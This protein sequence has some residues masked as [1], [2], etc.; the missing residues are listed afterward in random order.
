M[1]TRGESIEAGCGASLTKIAAF[2]AEEGLSGLE[3][4]YGI[5]APWAGPS[6]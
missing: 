2:A 4:A 5:P 1:E 6:S 3:F